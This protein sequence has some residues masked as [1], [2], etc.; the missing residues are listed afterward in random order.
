MYSDPTGHYEGG[1]DPYGYA[2]FGVIQAEAGTAKNVGKRITSVASKTTKTETQNYDAEH[3][4]FQRRP[5]SAYPTI[6]NV[7]KVN[8]QEA[9]E[10]FISGGRSFAV[11][12]VIYDGMMRPAQT[13]EYIINKSKEL[14][15]VNSKNE[16]S[17][18]STTPIN[19][20]DNNVQLLLDVIDATEYMTPELQAFYEELPD[21]F[22]TYYIHS[23]AREPSTTDDPITSRGLDCG[24]LAMAIFDAVFGIHISKSG[25]DGA[26]KRGTNMMMTST[27]ITRDNAAKS[28]DQTTKNWETGASV[29][30]IIQNCPFIFGEKSATKD[31]VN[32]ELL[33]PG[34]ILYYDWSGGEKIPGIPG[35]PQGT[36]DH[37]AIYVG[38][39]SDGNGIIFE[40]SGTDD[41][42]HFD[43]LDEA[44]ASIDYNTMAPGWGF[45]NIVQV[46]RYYDL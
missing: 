39:D 11:P 40:I 5:D 24:G 46:R 27:T 9:Q 36:T 4:D 20:I 30:T 43:Y 2:R 44:G 21:W 6:T 7:I 10:E 38:E 29:G 3:N 34:D 35:K 19:Q 1:Y 12:A 33:Q 31:A 26:Q 17:A 32:K 37:V 15:S 16:T 42:P 13:S 14:E 25:D 22:N 18:D 23:D 41:P 8:F 45:D 28:L